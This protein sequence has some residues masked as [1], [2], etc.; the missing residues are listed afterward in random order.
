MSVNMGTA[1][2]F[3]ELDTSKFSKGFTSAKDDLKVF[4]DTS[5]TAGQKLNGL[6]NAMQTVGGVATKTLT[7]PL[8]G[9]GLAAM[10]V[11]TDF[12]AGMSNVKAVSGATGT[13]FEKLRQRAIDL[14]A[15][16][17]FSA[18]EV[19][20]AMTEM[21]KAGWGTSEIMSGMEG[22]LN[23]A[24]ASGEGLAVVAGIVADAITGFGMSAKDSTKVADLLAQSANAGTISVSDL[25]ESFKYVA[26]IAKTM[27]LS[28]EDTVTA[29]TAMSKSGIKGS[30]A[31]TALRTMLSSMIKPTDDVAAAMD[32][33]GISLTNSDGSFKPL[34]QTLDEMRTSFS[35]LTDEQ[36]AYYANVLAGR[37]GMSGLTAILS[38][39][40][41]EYDKLSDSMKNSAGVAKQ[42]AEVMKDNLK[43]SVE[44]LGGALETAGINIGE[45]LTPS[46][47]KIT[48]GT[49][50]LVN[51]FND[52]SDEQQKN[53]V[54]WAGLATAMGPVA[55][56]TGK[57]VGTLGRLGTGF[58]NVGKET[59]NFAKA[60]KYSREG[61][62]GLAKSTSSL[63]AGL[64]NAKTGFTNLLSPVGMTTLAIGATVAAITTYIVK[65]EE[66]INKMAQETEAEK[67]LR[68]SIE[69]RYKV[70]TKGEETTQKAI[71]N[72]NA[73]A[74]A[75]RTL[76]EKL[77]GVVD[78]NGRVLAGKEH[79]AQFLVGELSQALG[80][81][82]TMNDGVIQ[83][84][85]EL[86]GTI[87]QVIEKKK[88]LAVQESMS[89]AY[90]EAV[91][92]Q[93]N[94]QL[95][96][97]NQLQVVF[98]NEQRVEEVKK[99]VAKAQQ[100]YNEA[101]KISVDAAEGY[102]KPL[103]EAN[104][105]LEAAEKKLKKSEKALKDAN[106]AM[107][108]FNS[109][110]E[111]YEGLSTA[112]ISGSA[113]EIEQALLKVEQGFLTAE[114]ATRESLT[115]QVE[116]IDDKYK[117]MQEALNAGVEGVTQ[118]MVD[119]MKALSEQARAE[120][121]AKIEQDKQVLTQ[122]FTELGIQAPQSLIDSLIQKDPE[123][124][125]SVLNMLTNAKNG[126]ALK[127][128]EI[129]TLF[130]QLG[131]NAPNELMSQLKGL[132]PSVQM[133]AISLL[134]QLQNAESAKRPEI[135]SQLRELGIQMDDNLAG[136][137]ESNTG[138]VVNQAGTVGDKA[139]KEIATK[140]KPDVEAP[141]VK[142]ITNASAVGAKA[143]SDIELNFSTPINAIVSVTK[144]IKEVFDGSHATGLDYVPFN[145][146]VAQLH[147]GERVLTKQENREYN[148][149]TRSG[150]TTGDT[151]NFYNTQPTPY[152]YARQMKRAKR[153]L[154]NGF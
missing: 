132:E 68:E 76:A 93:T 65:T 144:V 49:K 100:D 149:G 20:D 84:Y 98:D 90:S 66:K 134:L 110:V 125:Q 72:A 23:A 56:L 96:Y 54:K 139:N 9:V 42:T 53:I 61:L 136:G 13:E 115:A 109:T 128:G 55:S 83:N 91:K 104:L 138:K 69:E 111:N 3:L 15:S 14:G 130:R 114:T 74:E 41:Q 101:L 8:M 30:Q 141:K 102:K 51:E 63:Y 19:A 71:Q 75:T 57:T 133:S 107:V 126:T 7:V 12:E 47:R 22:V 40:Q 122:K 59:I 106:D 26:P 28:I 150:G 43:G 32:E 143:R 2:A 113:E 11:S 1:V 78:E 85:G 99:K 70:Y 21:A 46:F 108:G 35:G 142:E 127:K 34:K 5:A 97:A 120:L 73:E 10:K 27:G 105:E 152:E 4:L 18:T 140:V 148:R 95:E 36:K 121:E 64:T 29:I 112:L 135:V 137:I 50:D 80:Q 67:L 58:V 145:G 48:D 79:Y 52:L 31:G 88:A 117:Q 151:F 77:R 146:Y 62:D 131:I 94:A 87:D 45:V 38:M 60:I 103:H 153:D 44:E 81:E 6:G 119:N 116:T 17:T 16:T 82:I 118:E 123:V 129:E 147:E 124:Q 92:N 33:L 25:G 86:M 24:S 154:L 89:E 39:S 37:E